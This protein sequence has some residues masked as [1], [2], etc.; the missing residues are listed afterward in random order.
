[1]LAG[2]TG[3]DPL[4]R[5]TGS[6]AT[7][8]P[9]SP[10]WSRRSAPIS[11]SRS[12]HSGRVYAGLPKRR[13]LP[14]RGRRPARAAVLIL[15]AAP[16]STGDVA[17]QLG[18]A[19][20]TAS[21]HLTTLRNAGLATADRAGQRLLYQRTPLGDQLTASRSFTSVRQSSM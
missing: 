8:G 18:V 13:S 10:R 6:P 3:H 21:H 5:S 20:G 16:H 15:L 9:H 19:T 14:A 1:M 4:R 17:A 2:W 11:L 12:S 7:H